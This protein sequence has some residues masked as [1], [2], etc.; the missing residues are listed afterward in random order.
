MK[1]ILVTTDLSNKSKAGLFFAIQLASQNKFELTFFHVCHIL[2]S[3]AWN[4]VRI[5]EYEKEQNKIIQEK[6]ELFVQKIYEGLN[7]TASKIKYVINNSVLPQSCIREYAAE[8]EFS[9]ICIS[10]RGAGKFQRFL[11][12]T[13]GN[14]ITQSEI[15]RA[16]V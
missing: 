6:L 11:G 5:E 4:F 3:T 1:K 15:G 8:N 13:T 12:T 14:L 2:T 10:T 16:H 7:I 9:F